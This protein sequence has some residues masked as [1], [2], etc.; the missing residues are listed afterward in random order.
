MG[1]DTICRI[2]V[3]YSPQP[4]ELAQVSLVLQAPC[5]V[6]QALQKSGLLVRFPEI[7]HPGILVGVWGRRVALNQTLR[8]Q[9]RVEVYR[10]LR[11]DPKVAR[12][13]RFVKQ[14]A[15]RAGLFAKRPPSETVER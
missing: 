6:L 4:R 3:V 8:D 13:E 14:G 10:P 12:R 1:N 7:D 2:E 5:N 15:R 11:V 9:D